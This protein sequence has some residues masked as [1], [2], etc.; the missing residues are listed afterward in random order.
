VKELI[1]KMAPEIKKDKPRFAAKTISNYVQVVKM[2]VASAVNDKGEAIYPVKWDHDFMDLPEIKDQRTPTFAAEEISTIEYS[3]VS[4]S[5][6]V[7]SS[8]PTAPAGNAGTVPPAYITRPSSTAR[9]G[10]A[11][12][13][14]KQK[15]INLFMPYLLRFRVSCGVDRRPLSA[16][17]NH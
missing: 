17:L 8:R 16:V 10:T 14:S 9:T 1:A 7:V 3:N 5:S 11:R 2:V 6:E 12:A 13:K 4:D 15:I